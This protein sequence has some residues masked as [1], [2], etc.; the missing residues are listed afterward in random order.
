MI[1]IDSPIHSLEDLASL[2]RLSPVIERYRKYG[3][4]AS[5]GTALAP[6]SPLGGAI[7]WP[8]AAATLTAESSD[9]TDDKVSGVGA[10][11]VVIYGLD[12]NFQNVQ[13]SVT[14]NG[15]TPVAT[16]ASFIR[17]NRVSVAT[18]GAYGG[19]NTGNISVKHGTDLLAY[20]PAG[21]G[22]TQQVIYTVPAGY[23]AVVESIRIGVE[24]TKIATIIYFGRINA[25]NVSGNYSPF[26]VLDGNY[27][28]INLN[29]KQ[30]NIALPEKMD[31]YAAALVLAGNGKVN[32][33]LR[34]KLY[35]NL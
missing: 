4:N 25:H 7:T 6:V 16:T 19:I 23:T 15:T 9:N 11:T 2:G 10:H 5:V 26:A 3:Y 18:V 35:K 29:E 28:L 12:A 14:L 17:V 13:E 22:T 24:S 1:G 33:N 34:M 8:T 21:Y 30:V 27:G 32:V 31:V 20:V